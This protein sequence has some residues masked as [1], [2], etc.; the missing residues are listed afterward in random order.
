MQKMITVDP[1]KCTGCR[2]CELVCTVK[3]EGVSNPSRAR[4]HV[5]KWEMECFEIPMLCQQC[6]SALCA[7]VCPVKAVTR[8]EELGR[9]MIDYDLCI[10]CKMCVL[11]CPFGAMKYDVRAK[12][13][14]KCDLCDGEPTCVKFCETHALEYVDATAANIMKQREAASKGY[15]LR[16]EQKEAI[17]P[18]VGHPGMPY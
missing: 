9:M 11:A 4:I 17:G 14:I 10:G 15:E 6:D 16:R 1:S 7:A 5:V 13:V 3:H 12:R 2:T 8:D 18:T